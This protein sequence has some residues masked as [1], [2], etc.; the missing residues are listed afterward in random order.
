MNEE[1]TKKCP[2]C[3]ETIKADAV[4]C[5][6]CKS[7]L[8][9]QDYTQAREPIIESEHCRD[10]PGRIFGGVCVYIAAATNISVT[11]AR[12]AFVLLSIFTFPVGLI[13]YFVIWAVTPFRT[14]EST[15][16]DRLIEEGK[17]I[18]SHYSKKYSRSA[19]NKPGT[20]PKNCTPIKDENGNV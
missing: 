16:L 18:Y 19:K 3:K 6:Y 8:P 9:A 13:A 2:Y 17:N 12:L 5:R 10:L 14:G 20:E 11:V 15:L 4:K 7:T 1:T